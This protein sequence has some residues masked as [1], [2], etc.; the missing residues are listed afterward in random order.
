M[1]SQEQNLHTW[2]RVPAEHTLGCPDTAVLPEVVELSDPCP[3]PG[4]FP[5]VLFGY[6]SV[7]KPFTSILEERGSV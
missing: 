5:K 1:C 2:S 3:G 4:W 7:L 6:T